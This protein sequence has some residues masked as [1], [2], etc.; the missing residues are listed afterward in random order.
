MTTLSH[1]KGESFN[2]LKCYITLEKSCKN[3]TFK[4]GGKRGGSNPL[5]IPAQFFFYFFVTENGSD[6]FL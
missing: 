2:S 6:D 3:Q 5:H 4:R 1:S